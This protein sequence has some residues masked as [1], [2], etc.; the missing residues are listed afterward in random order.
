MYHHQ[1]VNLQ[2]EL[3]KIS[4]SITTGNVD[5]SSVQDF[6]QIPIINGSVSILACVCC[7]II[8]DACL[9]V[10]PEQ[11]QS[12]SISP[13]IS[14]NSL[15]KSSQGRLRSEIDR[16]AR[17]W[18][19]SY[20][21][22]IPINLSYIHT[23]IPT[24][25]RGASLRFNFRFKLAQNRTNGQSASDVSINKFPSVREIQMSSKGFK[26]TGSDSL[27]DLA[28]RAPTK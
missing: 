25:L 15:A 12:R 10:I 8:M 22:P 4:S 23:A 14:Q 16:G 24:K 5:C 27:T 17:N 20:P 28:S 1:L 19:S 13:V 26:I 11:S 21:L 18:K 3:V 7:A 2:V 9:V 6:T